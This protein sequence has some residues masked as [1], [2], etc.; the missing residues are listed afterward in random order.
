[1]YNSRAQTN[2]DMHDA[3]KIIS[4][5]VG[6]GYR[7]RSIVAGF[8]AADNLRYLAEEENIHVAQEWG[9]SKRTAEWVLKTDLRNLLSL[10]GIIFPIISSI[11]VSVGL[12][13]TGKSVSS[14][15]IS[16]KLP[17]L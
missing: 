16:L 2:R 15:S 12:S 6:G 11:T 4:D 13:S 10:Q 14:S 8:L 17:L 1:M 7:P 5:M 9:P 3:L